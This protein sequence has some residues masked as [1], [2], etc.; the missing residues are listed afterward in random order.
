MEPVGLVIECGKE[1]IVHRCARCGE[2]RICKVSTIDDRDEVLKI[3][4]LATRIE[5]LRKNKG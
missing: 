2:T 4:Q 3:S 1:S 5:D